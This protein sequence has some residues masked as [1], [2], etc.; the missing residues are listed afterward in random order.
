[1][2]NGYIIIVTLSFFIQLFSLLMQTSFS[3]IWPSSS[4]FY[5]QGCSTVLSSLFI[6]MPYA[7]IQSVEGQ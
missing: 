7:K 5:V 1:M 4:N 3:H 2:F 6:N